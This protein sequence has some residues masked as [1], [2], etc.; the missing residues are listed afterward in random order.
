MIETVRIAG[1]LIKCSFSKRERG[2]LTSKH[3]RSKRTRGIE[4]GERRGDEEHASGR[5]AGRR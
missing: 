3:M 4:D 2:Y 5:S 1:T